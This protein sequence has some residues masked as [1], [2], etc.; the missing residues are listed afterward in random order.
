LPKL[1]AILG[2][3]ASG[4]SW[5]HAF[6]AFLVYR[7]NIMNTNSLEHE[8]N[9]KL[10]KNDSFQIFRKSECP[11]LEA[12]SLNEVNSTIPNSR[13][14]NNRSKPSEAKIKRK[15]EREG[16]HIASVNIHALDKEEKLK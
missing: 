11:W 10:T 2:R 4:V 7:I 3:L 5:P 14:F 6:D 8:K 16:E 9:F 1:P 12:E 13:F 15:K